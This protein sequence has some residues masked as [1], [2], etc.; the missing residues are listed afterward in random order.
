[1]KEGDFEKKEKELEEK[2]GLFLVRALQ[3][4]L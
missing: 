1:M 3:M 2:M 4:S